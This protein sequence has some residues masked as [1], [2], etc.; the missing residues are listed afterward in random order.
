ME[1]REAS[2]G[3]CALI[4]LLLKNKLFVANLGDCKGR[5]FSF[6]NNNK[7]NFYTMKLND[8]HNVRKINK[9]NI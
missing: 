9:K 8:V 1:R 4:G 5:I 3:T 6:N 2:I 7:I